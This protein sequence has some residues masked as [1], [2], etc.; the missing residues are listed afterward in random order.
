MATRLLQHCLWN[1]IDKIDLKT[2]SY[3]NNLFLFFFLRDFPLNTCQTGSECFQ[4][5]NIWQHDLLGTD[6]KK[7]EWEDPFFLIKSKIEFSS[8]GALSGFLD[9]F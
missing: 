9:H 4:F 7:I 3:S 5:I 1:W 6:F 8:G 2:I